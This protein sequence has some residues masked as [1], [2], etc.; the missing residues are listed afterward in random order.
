MLPL[1]CESTSNTGLYYIEGMSL[2]YTMAEVSALCLSERRCSLLRL[3]GLRLHDNPALNEAVQAE[4]ML[5]V[6]CL[7]PWFV[8]S[9]TVGSNRMKFLLES[10][11][12]LDE[13]LTKRKSGLL[14]GLKTISANFEIETGELCQQPL[15]QR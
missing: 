13:N 12:D 9:K 11:Q 10:L 3:Q 1:G 2:L 15:N 8:D 6:F 4:T 14:V 7:D 5:P